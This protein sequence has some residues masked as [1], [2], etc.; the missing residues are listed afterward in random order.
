VSLQ[1]IVAGTH[2]VKLTCPDGSVRE[3]NATVQAATDTFAVFR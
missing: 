1:S 2:R 3:E